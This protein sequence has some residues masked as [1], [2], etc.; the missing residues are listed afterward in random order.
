MWNTIAR[1]LAVG[2]MMGPSYTCLYEGYIEGQIRARYTGFVPQLHR[3]YNVDVG[4]CA[5]CGRYD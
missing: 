4:G 1:L 3:R 2:S 5:Q